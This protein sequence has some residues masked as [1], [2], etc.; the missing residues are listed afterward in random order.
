MVRFEYLYR[1]LC[2]LARAHR[3]NAM[4]GHLGAA[5]VAGYFFGEDHP[6][7]DDRVTAA[8]ERELDRVIQGEESLWYDAGKAGISVAEMFADFPDEPPRKE[9]IATLASALARNIGRTRQSGHN[10]IFASLAIRALTD[11]P[12]YATPSVVDGIGRLI[13]AF[14]NAVPGR[15]YYGKA[16]G[17]IGGDQAPL[18]D[19]KDF[20]LYQDEAAMIEA[21]IDELIRSASTRRQGFG[22]LFHLINHAAGLVELSVY[23]H[24]DLARKGLAAHHFH[25]RLW[26]SLPDVEEELGPLKRAEHDPRTAEYWAGNAESQWSAQLTHRIKT[27]FGFFTLT[28][29]L[30]DAAK[31][32]QAER[33]FLYLM[34]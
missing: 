23:G 16:R 4:A 10:V 21:V 14:D 26:R 7:L 6:D 27:L 2:G 24:K 30:N 15:G 33:E 34:A 1:G 8:I 9:R 31:R 22:G 18:A 28:P 3:A 13:A 29:M 32:K 12:E 25:M 11:H 19:D 5:V 17:W 20:P